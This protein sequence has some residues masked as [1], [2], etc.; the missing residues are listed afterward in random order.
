M[1]EIG[2]L[3]TSDLELASMD[4]E[5]VPVSQLF[6]GAEAVIMFFIP[7][8]YGDETAQS[9]EALLINVNSSMD[10]FNQYD[11]RVICI[12]KEPPS[13]VSHWVSDREFQ[14][15]CYSDPSLQVTNALAGT[16]DL[17]QFLQSNNGVSMG[18]YLAPL[19]A[20]IVIGSDGK[21]AARY[22]ATSPG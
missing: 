18:T 16:F 11:L 3:V 1:A 5:I 9:M 15:D 8:C 19:P 6:Y 13:T 2:E 7:H 17:S 20:V 10:E 14:F 22:V 4:S 21:V 12:S